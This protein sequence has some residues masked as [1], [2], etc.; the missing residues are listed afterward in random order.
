MKIHPVTVVHADGQTGPKL[1][2]AFSN[3]AN[4]RKYSVIK[5]PLVAFP[6]H[7]VQ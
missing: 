1:I 4:G 5:A 3:F 6:L 2:V 7:H